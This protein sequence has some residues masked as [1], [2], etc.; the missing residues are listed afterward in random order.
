MANGKRFIVPRA[1]RVEALRIV[2]HED[3]CDT[4][5][6]YIEAQ[7][8]VPLGGRV[9]IVQTIQSGGM[10]TL[11]DDGYTDAA[12]EDPYLREVLD[13]ERNQLAHILRKLNVRSRI[14]S[15]RRAECVRR[16]RDQ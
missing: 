10:W 2:R 16:G 8:L 9:S 11:E 4:M 7:I 3:D 13:A 15:L 14:P 5:G 1:P 6:L 12:P